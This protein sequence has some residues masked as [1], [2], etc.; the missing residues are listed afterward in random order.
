MGETYFIVNPAKRQYL[1][2]GQFNENSKASGLMRLRHAFAV[3][4]LVCNL[5]AVRS[6][7]GGN[8]KH[9]FGS[10]AGAWCGDALYVVGDMCARPDEFGIKTSTPEEPERTLFDLARAEYENITTAA[11]A[12]LCAGIDGFADDMAEQAAETDSPYDF[13]QLANVALLAN[14]AE[15]TR[16]LDA[17][18]GGG[19]KKKYTELW[20]KYGY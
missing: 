14:S 4:A 10:L 11:I 15:M 12:M 18:F 13:V 17:T 2:I 1:D 20:P 8:V 3:S 5:D 6:S 19:W 16:A 9:G 7:K